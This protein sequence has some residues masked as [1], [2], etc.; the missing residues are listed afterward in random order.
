VRRI[1]KNEIKPWQQKGWVI[2]AE[3][4]GSFVANMEMVLD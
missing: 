3:Q 4:N 1:L 2:P